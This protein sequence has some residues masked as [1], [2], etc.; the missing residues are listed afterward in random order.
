[1]LNKRLLII[2]ALAV[3][4]THKHTQAITGDCCVLLPL[5]CCV[6][7]AVPYDSEASPGASSRYYQ[8]TADVDSASEPGSPQQPYYNAGGGIPGAGPL[9]AASHVTSRTASYTTA[10]YQAGS[11][12]GRSSPEATQAAI[13]KAIS[14]GG[15]SPMSAA[16]HAKQQLSLSPPSTTAV[17]QAGPGRL[18]SAT[19]QASSSVTSAS[20]EGSSSPGPGTTTSRFATQ[21]SPVVAAT[22]G[23]AGAAYMPQVA[24]KVVA[25]TGAAPGGLPKQQQQ[26]WQ[27]R[28]AGVG[29]GSAAAAVAMKEYLNTSFNDSDEL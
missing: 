10:T 4:S 7:R 13:S 15:F 6:R 18:D 12:S 25:V 28:A 5:L 21:P 8:G 24:P 27:Q 26:Q 23:S 2:Q 29:A 11:A 1:M 16:L 17:P 14:T 20:K 3:P 22:I 9:H 19:A